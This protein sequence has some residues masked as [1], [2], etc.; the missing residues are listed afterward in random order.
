MWKQGVKCWPFQVIRDQRIPFS[1]V[2]IHTLTYSNLSLCIRRALHMKSIDKKPT[3]KIFLQYENQQGI[4]ISNV[5]WNHWKSTIQRKK[6]D[7]KRH[8]TLKRS[9]TA[10]KYALASF[11][12]TQRVSIYISLNQQNISDNIKTTIRRH[13]KMT[14][15]GQ[16]LISRRVHSQ[17][18]LSTLG[19]NGEFVVF[20]HAGAPNH[21]QAGSGKL[22]PSLLRGADNS[23]WYDKANENFGSRRATEG[24]G[25]KIFESTLPRSLAEWSFSLLMGEAP[26]GLV[27]KQAETGG[28][29][30]GYA[31]DP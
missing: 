19:K 3:G 10:Y 18:T 8:F 15:D 26:R 1:H 21:P 22:C 24:L 23:T 6:K 9:R 11:S 17:K 12:T 31:A 13:W 20:L 5:K 4:N 25:S 14:K 27:K 30:T 28:G 7:L 16:K 2:F 29:W